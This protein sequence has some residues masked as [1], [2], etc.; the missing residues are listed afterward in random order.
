M[1]LGFMAVCGGAGGCNPWEGI[2]GAAPGTTLSTT[3]GLLLEHSPRLRGMLTGIPLGSSSPCS[4][5]Q[6]LALP[7]PSDRVTFSTL[8]TSL[9]KQPC[10]NHNYAFKVLISHLD[11]PARINPSLI[12]HVEDLNLSWLT[13]SWVGNYQLFN[14]GSTGEQLIRGAEVTKSLDLTI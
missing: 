5:H 4:L 12:S 9:Q 2:T 14:L 11:S 7:Y 6:L 13:Q 3:M 1:L 8:Q 10:L